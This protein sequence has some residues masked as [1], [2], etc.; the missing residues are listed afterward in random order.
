MV[1]QTNFSAAWK[2]LGRESS[3]RVPYGLNIHGL[4]FYTYVGV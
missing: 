2:S 1:R 3:V 4:K